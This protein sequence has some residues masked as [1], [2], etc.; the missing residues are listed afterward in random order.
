MRTSLHTIWLL[1]EL[2]VASRRRVTASNRRGDE[3]AAI[4]IKRILKKEA[5]KK[6][7]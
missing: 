7:F 5:R 6:R 3:E 1:D 4:E 2:L